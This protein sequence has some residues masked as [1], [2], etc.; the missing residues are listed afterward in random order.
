MGIGHRGVPDTDE[1]TPRRSEKVRTRCISKYVPVC[2]CKEATVDVL[3]PSA[4]REMRVRHAV[5]SCDELA[6]M[7]DSVSDD[8]NGK[9]RKVLQRVFLSNIS[10]P[11]SNMSVN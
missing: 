4:L 5:R 9:R 10:L 7:R 1:T 8:G 11:L 2:R 6:T 3:G